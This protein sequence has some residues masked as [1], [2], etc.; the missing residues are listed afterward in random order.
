METCTG[1]SIP[2]HF[3][4]RYLHTEQPLG[5]TFNRDTKNPNTLYNY[6]YTSPTFISTDVGRRR[7]PSHK[8]HTMAYSIYSMVISLRRCTAAY[9]RPLVYR[10]VEGVFKYL[11]SQLQYHW[12]RSRYNVGRVWCTLAVSLVSTLV[13][14]FTANKR[15]V[16]GLSPA[17]KVWL[18]WQ[19]RS[20]LLYTSDAADE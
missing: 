4:S 19:I 10:R 12:A 15:N 3:L 2:P 9:R 8:A 20:C 11:P 18:I 13:L 17:C 7:V 16:D 6:S 5:R 1:H 14:W